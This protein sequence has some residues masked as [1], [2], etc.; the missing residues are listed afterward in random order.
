MGMIINHDHTAYRST[1]EVQGNNK[2]NGA[3]YYSKEICKYIIPRVR[4]DRNWVTINTKGVGCD[5]AIVFVHNNLHPENY[6]WLSK[7]KDLVLVCG[8]K[9]TMKKVQ[10]L[11]EVV[12]LPLSVDVEYV[13]KFKREK[14]KDCAFAGR[15]SKKQGAILP[16][17]CD[18]L[19][20]MPRTRLLPQMAKYRTIYA[21]G[22]TAIEAKILGCK[23]APYDRR[24]PS[25]NIWKILD[26]RDAAKILQKELDRIDGTDY[27]A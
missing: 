11:G 6:Q 23:I 8:V 26:C 9:S 21:V 25:P 22:R 12:Y 20:G 2:W 15:P 14:T 3:F 16:A 1:W 5:Y 7:Y 18:V 4:T 24:F 19:A 27:G 17:G 10:H 13:E